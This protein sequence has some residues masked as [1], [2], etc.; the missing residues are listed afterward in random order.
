MDV[1]QLSLDD[2]MTTGVDYLHITITKDEVIN[3]DFTKSMSLLKQLTLNRKHIEYYRERVD[4]AFDG[5]NETSEELWE[6][7]EVRNYV[8]ELDNRFPYWLYFLSKNGNGLIVIIKCFLL[9]N[10][11]PEGNK[12]Y[13][14]KRLQDYLERRGFLAM[15][16]ILKK[17]GIS[18]EENIQMT[19]R[20]FNYLGARLPYF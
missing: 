1:E 19:E 15:N 9:P 7:P 20:V 10:L 5:Y 16:Y 18:M 3:N 8:A 6:I 17:G 2:L 13:N 4:I 12:L 11:T 14:E